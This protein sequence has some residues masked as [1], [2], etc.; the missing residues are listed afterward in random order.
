MIAFVGVL[1]TVLQLV[2][3]ELNIGGTPSLISGA[4]IIILVGVVLDLIR[5][6]N[7]QLLTH[8]YERFY[9]S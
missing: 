2:F 5:Q 7:A 1:P 8:H 4:G 9:K 3:T 6:V